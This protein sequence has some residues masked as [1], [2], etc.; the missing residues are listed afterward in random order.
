[1]QQREIEGD[2]LLYVGGF[3]RRKGID[4]L[5]MAYR[6]LGGAAPP[7]VLVGDQ[8]GMTADVA[9]LLDAPS[10]HC[11]GRLT[12]HEVRALMTKA[13]GFVWPSLSEGFGL[14]ALEAMAAGAPVVSSD[15][16]AMVETV[17]DAAIL[18]AAGCVRA[19]RDAISQMIHDPAVRADYRR[20]GR[21][22]VNRFRWD[23]VVP[24]YLDVYRGLVAAP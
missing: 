12:D 16:G 1:L 2:F 17:G 11:V 5:L 9:A 15:G 23:R 3:E 24:A 21:E 13:S 8:R 20:R 22:H 7:L 19:C 18:F 14:P 10:I 6:E 4:T